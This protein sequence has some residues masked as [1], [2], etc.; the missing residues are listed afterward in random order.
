MIK[1]ILDEIANTSGNNDKMAVLSKY[2]DNE[3]LKEVLYK[4]K[5]KRVKYYIKQIP[6]YKNLNLPLNNGCCY[7]LPQI[8]AKLDT[9]S[10]KE[11]TGHAAVGYLKTLLENTTSDNAYILERI[12]DRSLKF[13]L[14][15]SL[16]NKVIPGLIEKTPYMGAKPFSEALVHK[17]FATSKKVV[18]DIKADGRYANAIIQGNDTDLESRDGNPTYIGN[19]KIFNDLNKFE[20]CVLNGEFTVDGY[21]RYT[22]NGIIASIVDIEGKREERTPEATAKKIVAFNKKHDDFD[23][24]KNKIRYIV[25]DVIDVDE[26][27]AMESL[28]PYNERK[29]RLVRLLETHKP[30]MISLIESKEVKDY[31]EAIEH[32]KEA[33]L[34][35]EEGTIL[36]AYDGKWKNGKPNTQIKLKIE[37]NLDLVIVGFNYGTGKNIDVISSLNVESSDGILKTSP[38]G[39]K[40]DMMKH[41]TE[42]QDT[43]LG[44][45]VEIK[46]S[47]L[48]KDRKG[49][50]SVLHPVFKLIRDDKTEANSFQECVDIYDAKLGLTK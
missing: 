15:T 32:F 27:F 3:L 28:T 9:F 20:D 35:G 8:L 40:E 39:M 19:A 46:C 43:L 45:I 16:M 14:G 37:V 6:E 50:H 17:L 38:G 11:L 42:N 36:K 47:G 5:S 22:A 24:M 34:N 7:S 41:I 48:S 4:A 10:N 13:G 44:G 21:D 26:Y 23:E 33:L 18:S 12:I 31:K 25:W 29:E 30:E 2:K 49:N 1:G